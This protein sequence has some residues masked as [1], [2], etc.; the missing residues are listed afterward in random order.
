M[1]RS[2]SRDVSEII[3]ITPLQR[4]YC[5]VFFCQYS[6]PILYHLSYVN[7]M[8]GFTKIRGRCYNNLIFNIEKGDQMKKREY[9]RKRPQV[10]RFVLIA[11]GLYAVSVLAACVTTTLI[12]VSQQSDGAVAALSQLTSGVVSAIAAGFVLYELRNGEQERIHQNDIEEASFLLQYNQAFIQDSNMTEVESLLEDQAFYGRTD[13]IITSENR[14]KFVNY[15]V[16][17]EGL[18]P[19][20]LRG[21]LTF[22]HI[23]DLMA[24]R[25][26]LAVNNPEI[27]EKELKRFAGDYRGCYKLYKLWT[28][29][30]NE[31]GY[32]IHLSDTALDKWEDFEKY[33]VL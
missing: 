21:I 15:L 32:E 14:Q 3:K 33:A 16:Y 19:L 20:I 1:A 23:D 26:Y 27:Q 28:Q 17:L 11:V 2:F 18:A 22:E 12:Y 25:F 29:Y 31:K 8:F 4:L 24:Y 5:A 9:H 30:R 6:I 7:V 13:P 10:L